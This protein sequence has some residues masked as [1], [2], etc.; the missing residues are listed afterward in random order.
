MS[1]VTSRFEALVG[2]LHNTPQDDRMLSA[3]LKQPGALSAISL[4]GKPLRSS[5]C[6]LLT[7][8]GP[9]RNSGS[10]WHYE[11]HKKIIQNIDEGHP[12]MRGNSGTLSFLFTGDKQ[13]Y[14]VMAILADGSRIRWPYSISKNNSQN[15]LNITIDSLRTPWLLVG[16]NDCVN[17]NDY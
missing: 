14:T 2:N 11:G 6:V 10:Q 4:D 16:S 13:Q 15:H 12:Q 3:N 5:Q 7:L 1:I 8:A 9:I 17:G